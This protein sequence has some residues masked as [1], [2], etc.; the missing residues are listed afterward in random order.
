[1]PLRER[2]RDVLSV[3]R[4]A[5]EYDNLGNLSD[6]LDELVYIVLSGKT[7]GTTC[8]RVFARL[9]ELYGSWDELAAASEDELRMIL[10][11][12]GLQDKK[13]RWLLAALAEIITREG[14]ASLRSVASMSDAEAES[15]LCGLPGVG[16]KTARCV[17]M[18]SLGRFVLPMDANV[19][20]LLTRLGCLP[21]GT[22][23]RQ[24]HQLAQDVVEPTDRHD[25]HVYAVIHGRATCRPQQPDCG[26]CPVGVLCPRLTLSRSG[27]GR[28]ARR[29]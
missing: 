24:G 28:R 23:Y 12:G 9:K 19:F 25:F 2:T 21:P 4:A 1:M 14:G 3:L 22:S 6:P 7:Q 13:T 29:P 8:Q 16:V 27:A 20:R 17:M 15:Y 18:Y 5:Y 10:Q 26:A 11:L